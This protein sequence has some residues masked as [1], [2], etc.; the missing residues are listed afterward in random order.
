MFDFF[1][2]QKSPLMFMMNMANMEEEDAPEAETADADPTNP[3]ELMKQAF[4]MQMQMMQMAQMLCMMPLQLMQSFLETLESAAPE[5]FRSEAG[6]S[7]EQ[8][9]GFRLGS[10]EIPPW[11]LAK[12]M[13]IDM[14][15]ENLAK[16]QRVLDFV[17]EA[18]PEPKDECSQ[19]EDSRQ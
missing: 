11:L 13:Q 6:E 3:M 9:G 2:N 14:S 17:F 12:L 5:L 1:D 19:R 4:A 15:P 18:M 16:L 8:K 10:L 7:E